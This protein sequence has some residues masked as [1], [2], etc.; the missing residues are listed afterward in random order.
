MRERQDGE[1]RQ[2]QDE[3]ADPKNFHKWNKPSPQLRA[4]RMTEKN[5]AL[6]GDFHGAKEMKRHA[7]WL[8]RVETDEAQW[9]AKEG[10]ELEFRLLIDR[11]AKELE[12]HER[13]KHKAMQQA[14]VVHDAELT[15][16]KMAIKKLE[17]LQ[18]QKIIPKRSPRISR[19]K[20]EV[21]TKPETGLHDDRPPVPT[22]RT[23]QRL[24]SIRHTPRNEALAL[25][26]LE[27]SACVRAH[28][29]K[30]KPKPVR[31]KKVYDF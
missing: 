30:D 13:L 15:P 11:H 22:P 31:R 4:V 20:L 9:K 18:S 10:M 12:A 29:S 3:W 7:A 21:K 14:E 19:S 17:A 16:L 2:F 24:Q 8:E 6:T 1:I 5:L 23:M 27:T 25:K 26:A 28:K